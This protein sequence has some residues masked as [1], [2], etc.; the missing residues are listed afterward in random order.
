ML[1][2][3]ASMSQI[4]VDGEM[5]AEKVANIVNKAIEDLSSFYNCQGDLLF[6]SI[7]GYGNS[8]IGNAYLIRHGFLSNYIDKREPILPRYHHGPNMT[9]AFEFVLEITQSWIKCR[10]DYRRANDDVFHYPVPLIYNFTKGTNIGNDNELTKICKRIKGLNTDD[11]H[12]LVFNVLFPT[13][14]FF[15][16]LRFPSKELFDEYL[17]G[18]DIIRDTASDF[19]QE[20]TSE[21]KKY[22]Y[23]NIQKDSICVLVNPNEIPIMNHVGNRII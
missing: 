7:I 21:Y 22:G 18:Y 2:Q 1:D 5:I 15:D 20:L 16:T 23:S 17:L 19:P 11:G 13:H 14:S 3:S 9:K 4:G 8:E 10:D 12:P 6:I